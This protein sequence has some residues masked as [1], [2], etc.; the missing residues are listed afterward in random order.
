MGA[1]VP[2]KDEEHN[3]DT[4]TRKC[5][6]ERVSD[7]IFKIVLTQG[8]NRQIRRMC[9]YFGYNVIKLKRIRI[10]NIKLGELKQG[11]WRQ[12]TNHELKELKNLLR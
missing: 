11:K 4:V 10:M 3:L 1:G 12:V 8:I 2:I 9:S 7:N 5:H 6:V